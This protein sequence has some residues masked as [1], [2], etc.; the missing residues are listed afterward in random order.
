[1]SWQRTN[2]DFWQIFPSRAPKFY[3]ISLPAFNN[4]FDNK[5]PEGCGDVK[6]S[7]S[8]KVLAQLWHRCL[9]RISSAE[10]SH[11]KFGTR[12]KVSIFKHC[13][14]WRK[15]SRLVWEKSSLNEFH[16][17]DTSRSHLCPFLARQR[18]RVIWVKFDVCCGFAY[19]LDRQANFH[20]SMC[21]CEVSG[22]AFMHLF[23]VIYS[24]DCTWNLNMLKKQPFFSFSWLSEFSTLQSFE[25]SYLKKKKKKKL[26][27]P[28]LNPQ[29]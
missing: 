13:F 14:S 8:T 29:K 15:A 1:M 7:R 10:N 23:K 3:M 16:C 24:H 27:I 2:C 4:N 18:L 25:T 6:R 22:C 21:L 17:S 12:A 28:K 9:L 26:R 11:L 20:F 5:N 19:L